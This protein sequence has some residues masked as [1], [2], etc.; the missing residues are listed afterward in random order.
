VDCG[1]LKDEVRSRAGRNNRKRGNAFEL[2]VAH[3]LASVLPDVKRVGQYGAKDDVAG[4]LLYLQCKKV[5]GLYPKSV[6]AL[7]TDTEGHANADQAV[8][9]VYAHPGHERRHKI[10]AMDLRDFV[11][12][13]AT[14][15][16]EAKE[17]DR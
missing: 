6:D 14:V 10:I 5:A 4:R 12:L 3:M 17:S 15:I 11:H 16:G 7:L 2:E 13:I 9:V 1:K 8:A